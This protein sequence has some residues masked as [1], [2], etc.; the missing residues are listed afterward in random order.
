MTFYIFY[1]KTK[2]YVVPYTFYKSFDSPLSEPIENVVTMYEFDSPAWDEGDLYEYITTPGK[3]H[4][5]L[6]SAH[7]PEI[8]SGRY[9]ELSNIIDTISGQLPRE[10]D[11]VMVIEAY[12]TYEIDDWRDD[13]WS[14]NTTKK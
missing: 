3:R 7:G 4:R 8:W 1:D 5:I 13:G 10:L 12:E 2:I 9:S 11:E 14:P 6:A